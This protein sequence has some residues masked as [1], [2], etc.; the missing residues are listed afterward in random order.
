LQ[1]H[2]AIVLAGFRIGEDIRH[3]LLV[4]RTQHKRRVVEG[5]LRQQGQRLGFNFE[6]LVA[7]ELR[8]GDVITG[9]QI[10]FGIILFEGERI[11]IV[12]RFCRHY[13][14]TYCPVW[15]LSGQTFRCPA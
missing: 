10:V 1:R 7:L 2:V 15:L 8:Y 13:A 5:L 4:R 12:K 11:L 9:K 14:L 3:L 6:D